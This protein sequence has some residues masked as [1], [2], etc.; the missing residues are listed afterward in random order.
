MYNLIYS[1]GVNFINDEGLNVSIR[2]T[3]DDTGLEV[4]YIQI[5]DTSVIEE[6]IN[7][8][9]LS[10][11]FKNS[12]LECGYRYNY[13]LDT[14]DY[15]V[16]T[17]KEVSLNDTVGYINKTKTRRDFSHAML[18]FNVIL[19][20]D[21]KIVSLK[22]PDLVVSRLVMAMDDELNTYEYKEDVS[23]VRVIQDAMFHE[24]DENVTCTRNDEEELYEDVGKFKY[25]RSVVNQNPRT[26]RELLELL[27]RGETPVKTMT[28]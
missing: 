20:K 27:K 9:V 22:N 12:E 17:N 15:L 6:T 10:G 4:N 14:E 23:V 25:L 18:M 8:R 13:E 7:G 26:Y 28:I 2:R 11:T 19:R 5:G 21:Y 1:V 24:K 16:C 3:M